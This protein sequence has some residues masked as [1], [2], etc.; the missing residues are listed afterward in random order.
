M[1][2]DLHNHTS[3]CNH[4]SGSMEDYVLK[5]IELNIDVFGFSDH[6]P[7]KFDQDFRMSLKQKDQYEKDVKLL[8]EKYK[9]QID[10]LLSYEVDFI[11]KTYVSKDIRNSR[12]DYLIGSVH[13]LKNGQSLWGFDN[14]DFIEV[15]K[16]KNI[17][18][19]YEEYFK[20]IEE[21]IKTNYFNI[22]G[23][24][25]LIKVFNYLPKRDIRLIANNVLKQIKK[26]NMTLEINTAGFRKPIKELYPS[27]LLLEEAYNIGIDITFSSDAHSVTQIGYK[28]NEA[29]EIAKNIGY[30]E[31]AIYRNKEKIMVEF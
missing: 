21:M 2:V 25:D 15:Y 29:M 1:R 10:I 11:D 23:H 16:N 18:E 28:Y 27:K 31:C 9:N 6:A 3:L 17:D 12:V 14:P 8:K 13:F 7:M 30:R 20:T 4:A 24:L 22:V 5:A 26:F 19:I